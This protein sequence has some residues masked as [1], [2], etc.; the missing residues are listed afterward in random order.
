MGRCGLAYVS[1]YQLADV[2]IESC[3]CTRSGAG[4]WTGSFGA[5]AGAGTVRGTAGFG[6]V[7]GM[8]TGCEP[9]WCA[10]IIPALLLD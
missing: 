8:S 10:C 3:P 1:A 4:T 9:G 5:G 2:R 7:S 6:T